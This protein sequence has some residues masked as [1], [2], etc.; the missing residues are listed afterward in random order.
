VINNFW[1]ERPVEN[2]PLDY[3][4]ANAVKWQRKSSEA[5]FHRPLEYINVLIDALVVGRPSVTLYTVIIDL[6]EMVPFLTACQ[7]ES[8]A[9]LKFPQARM[10][11]C[12]A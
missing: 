1:E 5:I 2:A 3:I 4:A 10:E 9:R 12:I 6:Q 7:A 8:L 11:D